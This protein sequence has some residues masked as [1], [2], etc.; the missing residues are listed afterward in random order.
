MR[1]LTAR[2][3]AETRVA[4]IRQ[5]YPNPKKAGD[6]HFSYCVTIAA[7]LYESDKS[8][9]IEL[10]SFQYPIYAHRAIGKVNDAGRFEEAW[11]M[12]TDVYE[13]HYLR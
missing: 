13:E 9:S 10:R 5:Q 7:C 8:L 11:N 6:R 2:E 3:K 1:T 4:L 12:L